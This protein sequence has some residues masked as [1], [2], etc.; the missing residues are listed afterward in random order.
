MEIPKGRVERLIM[1]QGRE[2]DRKE[3]DNQIEEGHKDER[4]R[5]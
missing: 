1:Q 4:E 5:L 3:R 2:K